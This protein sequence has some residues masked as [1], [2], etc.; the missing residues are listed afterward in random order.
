MAWQKILGIEHYQSWQACKDR[1]PDAKGN[2]KPFIGAPLRAERQ[3]ACELKPV[4]YMVN[5]WWAE[6]HLG[7]AFP[8]SSTEG[9]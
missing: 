2:S 1:Y 8:L 6:T 9:L 3:P 5:T 7:A 4:F